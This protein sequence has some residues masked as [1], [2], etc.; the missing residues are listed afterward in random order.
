MTVLDKGRQPGGRAA[1]REFAGQPIDHGAQFFTAR[2]PRFADTVERG[3]TAGWAIVWSRG[4][5]LWRSGA[6]HARPD[7]HPRYACSD[8]MR[9]LAERIGAG[10][11][12][13]RGVTVTAL[14]RG[15][16]GF[17]AVDD[18]GR[19]WRGRRLILNLPPAQLA[20]LAGDLL[21]EAARARLATVALEPAWA[22]FGT[23]ERDIDAAWPALELDDH[24]TLGWIA[25][26]HTKRPGAAPALTVHAR[27]DWSA[28][29]LDDDPAAVRAALDA[30][31]AQVVGTVAWREA[32]LH[33][34]RYARPTHALGAPWLDGGAD[35][36]GCGDWC[37]GGRV[38][39]A[40]LSGWALA[41]A[42]K[43][44]RFP[45]SN[46]PRPADT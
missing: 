26:D 41:D 11:P 45:L 20:A 10:V 42:L 17:V 1:T 37:L 25:R 23:L 35:I 12:V 21:S 22:L 39:G 24:P 32:Q 43:N 16:A 31:L 28:A 44:E 33:R 18:D 13:V 5:P 29:H 6:V 19:S 38:E 30:A 15:S 36:F 46:H 4:F 3:I 7:G 14:R 2:D 40:I 27:G 8:G 9:A 34:W